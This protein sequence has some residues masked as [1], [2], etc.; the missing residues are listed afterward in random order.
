MN[1]KKAVLKNA[2]KLG[3]DQQRI[4]RGGRKSEH[5]CIECTLEDGTVKRECFEE[6]DD[7]GEFDLDDNCRVVS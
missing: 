6:D 7:D 1:T 4:V 3:R 5:Y 2:Q